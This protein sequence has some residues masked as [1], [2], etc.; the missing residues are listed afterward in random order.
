LPKDIQAQAD[1]AFGLFRRDPFHPSLQFKPTGRYWSARIN[2]SYR[3]LARR[4]GDEVVWAWIGRHD[5]Y[6][7]LIRGG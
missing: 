5:E 4:D 1:K 7:R 6:E 2:Q 3:A